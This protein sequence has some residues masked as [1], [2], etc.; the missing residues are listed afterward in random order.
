[1]TPTSLDLMSLEES[2][3]AYNNSIRY[4]N[5]I[6]LQL[7]NEQLIENFKKQVIP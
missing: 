4:I 3:V 7:K 1:M 6:E 2:R 5:N